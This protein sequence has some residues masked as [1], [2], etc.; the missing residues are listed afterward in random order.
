[1][2]LWPGAPRRWQCPFCA[3][4][5]DFQAYQLEHSV[6]LAGKK[7]QATRDCSPGF[8]HSPTT[9]PT[10]PHTHTHAHAH[11]HT[12]THTMHTLPCSIYGLEPTKWNS[13]LFLLAWPA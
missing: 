1:M 5:P 13:V 3:H 8:A 9:P 12:H 2:S 7:K 4:V 6:S 11:T 10:T